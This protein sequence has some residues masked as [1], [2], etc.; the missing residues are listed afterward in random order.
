MRTITLRA[1]MA[2]ALLCALAVLPG[3]ITTTD[4][5]VPTVS[6]PNAKVAEIISEVQAGVRTGCSI[7]VQADSIANI[8]SA[9]GV[10]YVGLV[11]DV[12]GQVCAAFSRTSAR[13]GVAAAPTVVIK[14]KA[15]RVKGKR[16]VSPTVP[17]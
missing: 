3:C 13:R 5:G 2:G 10:P 4:G 1:G 9:V 8:L 16:I 12:V 7:A 15:I 14:G 17:G 11:S 6:T